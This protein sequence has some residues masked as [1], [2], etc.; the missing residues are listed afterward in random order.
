[1]KARIS[2]VHITL[3]V[4][5]VMS[6]VNNGIN[7][8]GQHISD[9]TEL[10]AL[11]TSRD[12]TAKELIVGVLYANHVV[13]KPPPVLPRNVLDDE[14]NKDDSDDDMDEDFNDIEL[15]EVAVAFSMLASNFPVSRDCLPPIVLRSQ[16]YANIKDK[17]LVDRELVCY[18]HCFIIKLS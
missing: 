7:A 1:M 13:A 12:R 6:A 10:D 17:T 3:H 5:Y 16:L 14:V 11:K 4:L 2:S 15:G 8:A 9:K 18:T